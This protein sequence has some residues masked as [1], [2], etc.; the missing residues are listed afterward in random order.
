MVAA[1]VLVRRPAVIRIL[2]AVPG[3]RKRC[4]G[5]RLFAVEFHQEILAD[6][7]AVAAHAA[8]VEVQCACKQAFVACHYICAFSTISSIRAG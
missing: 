5:F 1:L 6:R 4:H 2:T 8:S 7:A 3:V